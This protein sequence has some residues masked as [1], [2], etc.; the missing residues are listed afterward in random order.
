M[1]RN[2]LIEV[3]FNSSV[4]GLQRCEKRISMDRSEASVRSVRPKR[5]K[6]WFEVEDV[7]HKEFL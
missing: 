1:K 2:L 3:F 7:G 4:A 6:R 5:S